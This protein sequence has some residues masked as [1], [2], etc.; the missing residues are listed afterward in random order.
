M[1]HSGPTAGVARTPGRDAGLGGGSSPNTAPE[2]RRSAAVEEVEPLNYV[3]DEHGKLQAVIGFGEEDFF[4]LYRL[5]KELEAADRQPAYALQR[6][7][8]SG[9]VHGSCAPPS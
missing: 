4:R 5:K 2:G 9:T 1:R 7:V 8:G 6:L 3:R